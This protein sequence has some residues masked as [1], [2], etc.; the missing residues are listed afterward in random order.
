MGEGASATCLD[1]SASVVLDIV[2]ASGL[3]ALGIE[4]LVY[5]AAP[6]LGL[7]EVRP[8]Q[9]EFLKQQDIYFMFQDGLEEGHFLG[10]INVNWE[11]VQ[12]QTH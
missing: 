11:I 6:L 3:G 9:A 8:V 12:V 5:S 2:A 1:S 10:F 4:I 7:G